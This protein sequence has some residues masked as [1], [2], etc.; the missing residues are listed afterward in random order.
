MFGAPSP[1]TAAALL[2][3][4]RQ[5]AKG[6][7]GFAQLRKHGYAYLD[8]TGAIADLLASMGAC[9]TRRR[10]YFVRPRVYGRS[11]TLDV[12]AEMLRAGALPRG[13]AP[14][15]GYAPVDVPALFGGLQVHERLLAGDAT[16]RGLLQ[17]QRFVVRLYLGEPGT[18]SELKEAII[19]QLAWQAGAAFG[20]ALR[21]AVESSATPASALRRLVGAVPA[22]VPVAL[23]ADKCDA[24]LRYDVDRDHWARARAGASAL[25]A[26]VEALQAPPLRSRIELCLFTGATRFARAALTPGAS[27]LADLTGD[28]LVARA[29]GFSEAEV[30][31]AF[32]E[33]LA[34]LAQAQGTDERGALQ[35][36]TQWY[37]GCSFDGGASACLAPAP[38]LEALRT[39]RIAQ[40]R[41]EAAGSYRWLGLRAGD[42]VLRLV[43]ELQ[44]GGAAVAEG[45]DV[46]DLLQRRVAA[47][48]LLLQAGLLSVAPGQAPPL[49]CR[50]PNEYARASLQAMLWS[51]VEDEHGSWGERRVLLALGGLHTALRLRSPGAFSEAAQALLQLLPSALSASARLALQGKNRTAACLHATLACA[52]LA[53]AQAGVRVDLA[54]GADGGRTHLVLRFGDAAAWVV[55]VGAG[56]GGSGAWLALAQAR[57]AAQPEPSVLCC[58]VVAA[59]RAPAPVA[60]AWSERA[61]DAAGA[62]TWGPLAC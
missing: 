23:L 2:H 8:K 3:L 1:P 62:C 18:S 25:R 61:V 37:G 13:V 40:R 12:A 39:G 55:E 42:R 59:A 30:R 16:L 56:G 33:E 57:G 5:I 4:A 27:G 19:D 44:Q 60:C 17:R 50:P 36:L 45:A 31:A 15:P 14:W 35:L 48:P 58:A 24:V 53:T 22:A 6:S 20:P 7:P 21:A 52:L 54:P 32:P 11:L 9:A 38:V 29:L 49:Q 26:L 51:A 41:M 47:V 34:H 28:P 43:A 10:A 46:A